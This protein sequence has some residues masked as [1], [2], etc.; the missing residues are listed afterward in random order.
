MTERNNAR[1]TLLRKNILA[2]LLLK[3]WAGLVQLLLVPATLVCLGDYQNGL[4]MTIYSFLFWIE[5]LDIGLG[6]GLRNRL[7]AHLAHG[8]TEQAR[9]C[10][11]STLG[12]LLIVIIPVA[13]LLVWG[14]QVF[15]VYGW[16]NIRA[17]WVPDLRQVLTLTA[18]IVSGVFVLKFVGNIYQALQLPAVTNALVVAGQTLTLLFILVLNGFPQAEN[19]FWW[20]AVIYTVAQLVVYVVAFPITFRRYP[21]LRPSLKYFRW[22]TVVDLFQMGIRFFV[23]QMAGIVLFTSSNAL[24]SRMF[25]PAMVTPYQVAY[26]YFSLAMMLFTIVAVPYW[27]ATTD[28]FERGD[29]SWIRR[30]MKKMR[31]GLLGI[32]LLLLLMTAVANPVY[33]LWVGSVE[34]PLS[35]TLL[36]AAYMFIIIFSLSYSYFLNGMNAL[37]LQLVL[38]VCAAVA[39]IPLAWH[40][41]RL[42]GI[43][44]MLLALCVVN[45][46]GALVNAIQYR[47]IM[48]GRAKGIWLPSPSTRNMQA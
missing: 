7:S 40:W 47:L 37:N 36:M 21:F 42:W 4:W 8:Q 39:Y 17:D 33:R 27:S 9:A 22:Q 6:N 30:S 28:A 14:I 12:M 24:I 38:T 2:S 25:T 44:G 31:W 19:R 1:T 3:G 48:S 15:D 10:V 26:R 43:E 41:G 20:V 5:S 34:V 29:L 13:I 45:L 35:M 16:L 32:L 46:P 11:S 18:V 23:L